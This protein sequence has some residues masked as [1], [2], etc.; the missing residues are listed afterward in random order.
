MRAA[1]E[2]VN[3]LV[4]SRVVKLVR[5]TPEEKGAAEEALRAALAG[6]DR[7]LDPSG[8]LLSAFS[9]A[10]LALASFAGKLPARL[11]GAA[12]GLP[13]LARWEALVMERPSV[14]GQFAAGASP[15]GAS[16]AAG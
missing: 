6:I 2:R 16:P 12:L 1:T 8:Y 9:A 13:R 14:R 5:G 10:D 15:A 3:E 7:E 11:R 4:G